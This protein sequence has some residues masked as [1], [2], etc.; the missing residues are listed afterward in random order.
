MAVSIYDGAELGGLPARPNRAAR[1]ALAA[2]CI[3]KKHTEVFEADPIRFIE[4]SYFDCIGSLKTKTK[5][6]ATAVFGEDHPY[7]KLLFEKPSAGEMSLS[8]LRSEL[9]HGGITMLEKAHR[10]VI[11]RNLYE[12]GSITREFL[13]RILFCLKPSEDVPSWSRRFQLSGSAADPR[14]TMWSTTD[15]VFPEGTSWKIR[16]EWCE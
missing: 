10:S 4:Q 7:L 3:R 1:K 15:K 13:L 16:P 2:E 6:V 14:L 12:M 8:D 5:K 9:A 11:S